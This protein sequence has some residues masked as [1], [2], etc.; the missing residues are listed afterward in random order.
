M[1]AL[2]LLAC[3]GMLAFFVLF[4]TRI[5]RF[6]M[7]ALPGAALSIYAIVHGIAWNLRMR[8][9][10]SVFERTARAL[11]ARVMVPGEWARWYWRS[12]WPIAGPTDD[13]LSAALDF[14]GAQVFVDLRAFPD[15]HRLAPALVVLASG[16]L[17]PDATQRLASAELG[18][19]YQRLAA[20]GF[21]VEVHPS[22][23]V[24]RA[25]R[26]TVARITRTSDLS[27]LHEVAAHA[28][29]LTAFA[30]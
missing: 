2:G 6:A 17:A 4:E 11:H 18:A 24:L 10:R 26:E 1:G 15:L 19:L 16:R 29:R 14:G 12:A 28:A 21:V 9:L 30:S 27:V 8:R 23:L 20:L 5:P 3:V 7:V 13:A 25:N 22:G